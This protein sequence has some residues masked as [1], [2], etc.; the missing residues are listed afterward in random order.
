M[1]RQKRHFS[2][3]IIP[4]LASFVFVPLVVVIVTSIVSAHGADTS[5]IHACVRNS[6][7]FAGAPNIR[8]VGA[9]D[10]CNNNENSLDWNIQGVQGPPGPAGRGE[11]ICVT[12][13]RRDILVRLDRQDLV[14]VDLDLTNLSGSQLP[15][16]NLTGSS[17]VN[18]VL[19]INA[20]G[21]N[22]TDTDLT[23]ANMLGASGGNANFTRAKLN[24]TDLSF[25][26]LSNANFTDANLAGAIGLDTAT[27]TGI[28]WSNTTCPDGTNSNNNSGTCEGHLIP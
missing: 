25:M 17:F 10:N 7:V 21:A 14:N 18:A 16:E 19:I 26:D 22:F 24:G 6:T 4:A 28:V 1:K 27:R 11:F 5:K 15:N 3:P 2:L 23:N 8:I 12:C 20:Q 9:N 13:S